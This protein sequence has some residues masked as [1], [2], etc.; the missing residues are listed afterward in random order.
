MHIMIKG[1]FIDLD[2]VLTVTDIH[3][4]GSDGFMSFIIQYKNDKKL[5]FCYHKSYETDIK[6][7]GSEILFGTATFFQNAHA[8]I[9]KILTYVTKSN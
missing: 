4:I 7:V 8:D 1:N 3:P 9:I 5:E 6:I 2:D